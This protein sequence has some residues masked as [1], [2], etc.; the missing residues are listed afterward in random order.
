[1]TT[2]DMKGAIINHCRTLG[3]NPDANG[4]VQLTSENLV[5]QFTNWAE[6]E[7]EL[8]GGQGSELKADANGVVKFNAVHSSSALCVNN[9]AP[10]KLHK[11]KFSFLGST[12]FTE[13]TF[14]KKL[15][16]GVSTPNLDF[17]LENS[18]TVIGIESKFTEILEDKYPNKNLDK[19]QNRAGL[20]YLPAEFSE[21]LQHYI[22]CKA[23]MYLD[24]AQL[25][26]HSMGLI[27]RASTRNKFIFNKF[28][29]KP[30]LVY[31]YWQP[32]NWYNFDIY[33]KHEDEVAD[34]KKRIEAVIEFTPL[35]YSEFWKMYENDGNF[36]A[37]VQNVKAR[38]CI[39]V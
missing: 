38:Y 29:S 14:E 4:Y 13:A 9:F 18:H 1:M 22:D 24:V 28:L 5:E 25:L 36:G 19:Y 16:T 23:E 11:H 32:T 31:L 17:Y 33:R 34:F 21:V 26:K 37:H 20:A 35:S 2:N 15:P 39:S 7:S 6:I 27:N 8:G 30:K 3:L 12:D 10:F